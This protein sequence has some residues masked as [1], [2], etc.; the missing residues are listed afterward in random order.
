MRPLLCLSLLTACARMKGAATEAGPGE[1]T[2]SRD[3]QPILARR[4]LVCHDGAAG[5]GFSLADYE[6]AAA[7]GEDIVAAVESERMP[8]FGARETPRCTPAYGWRDD[9]RP[10]VEERALLQAWVAHG[11]PE[12]PS[13]VPEGLPR[14][15][16]AD[17][18]HISAPGEIEVPPGPDLYTCIDLDPIY[19]D[20][21]SLIHISEPTRH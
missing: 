20:S 17:G 9:P 6:T 2:W 12:G 11:T 21:L 7:L 13:T 4:C 3:V 1:V 5:A 10:T 8:P 16:D 18:I 14:L 15:E 19:A